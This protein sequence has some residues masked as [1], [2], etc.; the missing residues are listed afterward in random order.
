MLLERWEFASFLGVVMNLIEAMKQ[1][2]ETGEK[3]RCPGCR[4]AVQ[5]LDEDCLGRRAY[6]SPEEILADDW[7][8]VPHVG[9]VGNRSAAAFID[10]CPPEPIAVQVAP[11]VVET[12]GTYFF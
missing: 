12:A 11:G 7:E 6:L 5:W 10:Y 9:M 8:P 3:F 1:S 4:E 2:K